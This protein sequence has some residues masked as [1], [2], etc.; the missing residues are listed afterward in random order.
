MREAAL[1][2]DPSR[3]EIVTKNARCG[4]ASGCVSTAGYFWSARWAERGRD[5]RQSTRLMALDHRKFG[6]LNTRAQLDVV[7]QGRKPGFHPV[8]TTLGK[9]IDD[10]L[11]GGSGDP[12]RQHAEANTVQL[13]Q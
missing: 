1:R 12:A 11:Q 4:T 10:V 2:Q 7:D 8:R 9:A 6:Q 5:E 13:I 3:D